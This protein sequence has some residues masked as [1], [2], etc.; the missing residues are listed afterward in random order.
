[1]IALNL[2]HA[3]LGKPP[4]KDSLTKIIK[5]HIPNWILH[6]TPIT[7]QEYYTL[8]L[9]EIGVISQTTSRKIAI[10]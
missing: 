10:H 7:V 3:A 6:F 4:S 8:S 9:P 1:M 5:T 2:Q